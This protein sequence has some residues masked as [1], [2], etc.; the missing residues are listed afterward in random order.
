MKAEIKKDIMNDVSPVLR[1]LGQ[2]M[3]E[4]KQTLAPIAAIFEDAKGFNVIAIWFVKFIVGLGAVVGIIYG[5]IR[6]LK[7]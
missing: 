3:L 4:I 1:D 2:S 6:W 5:A 7:Q